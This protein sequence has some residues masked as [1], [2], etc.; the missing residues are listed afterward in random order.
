MNRK[1]LSSIILLLILTSFA[2]ALTYSRAGIQGYVD[3][4]NSNA[5]KAPDILKGLIG[6]ETVNVDVTGN[7]GSVF[8]VGF[9]MVNAR[10][11]RIVDGGFKDPSI[12]VVTTQSAITNVIHSTNPIAAFQKERDA[13]QVRV[14]GNNLLTKAKLEALLSSTSVLQYFANVFFG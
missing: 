14:Q 3:T 6:N 8:H 10:I 12:V 5:E 4:Y 2:S 1:I 11:N 7:D 13:G 9:E